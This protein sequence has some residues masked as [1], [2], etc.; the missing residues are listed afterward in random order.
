M[1]DLEDVSNII[2]LSD[3]PETYF[4]YYYCITRLEVMTCQ[5]LCIAH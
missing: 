1:I 2:L 5:T 4:Y 3:T